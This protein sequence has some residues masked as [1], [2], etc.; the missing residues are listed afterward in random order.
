MIEKLNSKSL[1]DLLKTIVIITLIMILFLMIFNK[2][3]GYF[4]DKITEKT[5]KSIN[6]KYVSGDRPG[7][8]VCVKK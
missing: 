6:Q 1:N 8:G 3:G 4:T 7:S 2:F 5:C